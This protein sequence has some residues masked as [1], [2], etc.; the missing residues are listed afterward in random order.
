MLLS[1]RSI[2][3]CRLASSAMLGLLA[4][5]QSHGASAQNLAALRQQSITSNTQQCLTLLKQTPR[6][7]PYAPKSD[8]ARATYCD[9]VA[10][11]YTAAMPDTL[12]IALAS[13]KL[14]DKP[15]DAAARA[16]AAAVHLDIARRQCVG[17]Q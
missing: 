12:L 16:R 6:L 14:Q 7:D 17:K 2:Q 10:R 4:L 11:T 1:L 9:C 5:A 15:G 13:G 8:T 3:A